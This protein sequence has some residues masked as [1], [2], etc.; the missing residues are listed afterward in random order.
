MMKL[1]IIVCTEKLLKPMSR[2][3]HENGP[4][5]RGSRSVYGESYGAKDLPKR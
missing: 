2:V 5:S 1:C 3:Q 4:I